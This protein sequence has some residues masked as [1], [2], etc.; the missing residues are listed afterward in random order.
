MEQHN[1]TTAINTKKY[2]GGILD[3]WF[4][5]IDENNRFCVIGSNLLNDDPATELSPPLLHIDTQYW[6]AETAE[7]FY[8]LSNKNTSAENRAY[9]YQLL[10][11]AGKSGQL[12]LVL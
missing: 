12:V 1:L 8:L 11:C 2:F 7:Y 4:I 5:H 3:N 6:L 10:K 9:H